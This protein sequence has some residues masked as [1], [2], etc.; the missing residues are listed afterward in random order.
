[1]FQEFVSKHNSPFTSLPMV[2]KS[3]TPSVTAAPILSTPR[4]QQVTESFLDLT[5][6]AAA[7]GIASII[8]VDP[9]AKA[10]NQVFSVCAHLTGAADLKYWA[11]LVRFESA[12]VPTT[13]T[14]TFDLFPIAGTYSN[15][16]YIVKDCATIKTFPYVAGKTVYV[17]LMLFSNSWVAGKLTGIISINQVRTEITTLQPLK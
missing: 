2:S 11:A 16:A 1:M 5:I 9:S 8:S 6:T 12:T 17:G 7:G 4:N 10:D 13:V 14:P 15:G 3:V